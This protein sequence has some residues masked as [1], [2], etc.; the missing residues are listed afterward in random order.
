MLADK[1]NSPHGFTNSWVECCSAQAL[2][3]MYYSMANKAVSLAGPNIL[4]NPRH[5]TCCDQAWGTV[6]RL[7]DDEGVLTW[8]WAVRGRGCQGCCQEF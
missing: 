5:P 2:T 4:Y 6:R 3:H 8:V 7:Q 1:G